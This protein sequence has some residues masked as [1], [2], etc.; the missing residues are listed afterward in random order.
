MFPLVREY[1]LFSKEL[2]ILQVKKNC[3]L[4]LYMQLADR[5]LS[6][7]YMKSLIVSVPAASFLCGSGSGSGS[8]FSL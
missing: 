2:Y 7:L 5:K 1:M 8:C 4:L 3:R 6:S